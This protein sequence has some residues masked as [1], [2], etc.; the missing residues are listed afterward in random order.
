MNSERDLFYL[1]N[2]KQVREVLSEHAKLGGGRVGIVVEQIDR[3]S[4]S[5]YS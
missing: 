5:Y 1:D 2:T 3:S 4:D